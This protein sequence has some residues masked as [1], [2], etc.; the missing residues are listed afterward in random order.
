[1]SNL[2][3]PNILILYTDQQRLDSLKCYG[4]DR[5]QTP[6]IDMLAEDGVLFNNYFTQSTVCTP[7]RMSFLTGRYCSALGVGT[8]GIPFPEDEVTL[9][10]Y[11]DPY[12]YHTAQIGKLHFLP[13][14][15][16]DHRKPGPTYGFDTFILSD[17]PGCYDDA[18]IKWVERVAP[19]KVEKVWT[20]LP[21][22]AKKY[23]LPAYS[24]IPRGTHEPYIFP[25]DKDLTHSA[26]VASE[27]SN[28]IKT[29]QNLK[30]P[31][32]AIGGFYAPHCPVNP[33]RDFVEKFKQEDMPLPSLGPD[34]SWREDLK[35]ISEQKWQE[36]R[37]YYLA[38]VSHVDDC[39][40]KIIDTLKETG[41]YENTIIIFTSDHG[42]YLGDHG[43]VGK[44]M[45]GHDCII[46][47]P[48]IMSYPEEI[49]GGKE[50][51]NLI[52]G[53][54]VVPTLLDYAGVQ[55][56]PKIQG[57][58]FKNL[59]EGRTQEHKDYILCE[60]FSPDGDKKTVIRDEKYKYFLNS[61]GKEILYDL[62]NDPEEKVN[63]VAKKE[64]QE[65]LSNLRKQMSIKLQKAAYDSLEREA[66]Y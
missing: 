39:V 56:P 6:N 34:D 24:D 47:V 61:S 51:N 13:H 9:N 15:R 60:Q 7:S 22:A 38:L 63:I 2:R 66:E 46:N 43:R 54:D 64:Y 52:E 53:V 33:P 42:E 48:F 29:R 8:N 1:M 14:A 27:V 4:N 57:K 32:M 44:G 55:V 59:L 17:E 40:G 21:P 49:S 12:G 26:F 16:R 36:I 10:Q 50:I 23:D 35:D 5:A 18:Y 3:R 28:Y 41:Q 65:V 19:D 30:E 45:P 20:A 62:Q 37:A 11:L 31:F 58:S 25:G